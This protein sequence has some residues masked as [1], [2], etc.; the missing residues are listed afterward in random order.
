MDGMLAFWL[1]DSGYQRFFKK[2]FETI[3]K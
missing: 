2:Y 3:S 1:G